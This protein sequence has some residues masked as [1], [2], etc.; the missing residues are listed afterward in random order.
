[1]YDINKLIP[2]RQFSLLLELLPSPKARKTGRPKCEKEALLKGILQVLILDVPWKKIYPC[3]AS[4][5]SCHRYFTEVQRRG[6]LH[7]IF[8][9]LSNRKTNIEEC[10]LDTDTINS[11]RFKSSTG[12]DGKHK[13]IGT[14]VSLLAD[15]NGLP[16]DVEFGKG[17]KHDL[18]FVEKHLQNTT[19]TRK[20]I[21]NLDKGYTSADLRRNLRSSGIYVN[22]E[23][24]QGDYKRK[25]GPKFKFKQDKYKVRFMV[26]R[27]FAWLENFRRIR[28]RREY[29]ITMFKAFVYLA[30]IIILIRN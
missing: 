14:K 12:W 17:N 3:G 26:E 13:K 15:K 28:L 18:K 9:C 2:L 30:L 16:A 22:M 19:G 20:N 27:C 24:R 4:A 6:N 10:A 29:K 5:S 25:K 23:M 11:F 1:M 21:L 8:T 7:L